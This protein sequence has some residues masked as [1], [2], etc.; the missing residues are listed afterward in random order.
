MAELPTVRLNQG[1]AKR[2]RAGH[3]WVY[4]NE[5]AM[6]AA[7]KAFPPGAIVHVVDANS[8]F[9]ATAMFNPHSLIAAR[10]L[11]RE[12]GETIDEKFL[13]G[14]IE[15]ALALRERLFG[16]PFYRLI[17]AEADGLPGLIIDRFGRILVAEV[18]SAGME[19][20]TPQ[21]LGALDAALDPRVVVLRNDSPVRNLEGLK[22]E[23]RVVKGELDGPMALTENGARFF[24]DPLGGQ[25][26]GWFYDQREA[27]ARVAALAT[28]ARVLD[29]YAY[30]GGFGVPAAVRGAARV[31]CVDR[32]RPALDLAAR[33]AAA[34][35]VA[36]RC[37]FRQGD[38]FETLER[39][40]ETFDVVI[41]DPPAFVRSKKDLGAG[42]R[43]Y[44]KLMRLAAGR[45]APGGFLFAASCSHHVT[46]ESFAQELAR[47]LSDAG[48]TGRII[49]SMG[50]GPD[51]PVHPQLPE[52]AYLKSIL[53]AL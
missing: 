53:V 3:P 46:P 22:L 21:L 19:A 18:N 38:A 34:N 17:H 29:L 13:R 1:H 8:A 37:E 51:H 6:D 2:L 16:E 36:D 24:A 23:T 35:G 26:T 41:A 11:S 20:L 44:R 30:T 15:I 40:E 52:S 27:R 42:L 7:A 4:S 28:G 14:R 49:A 31:V 12:R 9:L 5:I 33:A 43:G 25:K 45:V 50:A 48:R 39:M 32:S 10:V 47:A